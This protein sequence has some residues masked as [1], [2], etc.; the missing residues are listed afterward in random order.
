MPAREKFTDSYR[1]INVHA[2]NGDIEGI[3][4][5]RNADSHLVDGIF[6]FAKRYGR[7]EF[8]YHGRPYEVLRNRNLTYTVRRVMTD[9][10]RLA[11]ALR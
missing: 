9:E 3:D 6:F 4:F 11:D 10:E 7:S 1:L 5:L 2:I 8:E